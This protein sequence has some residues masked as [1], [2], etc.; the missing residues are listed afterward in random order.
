MISTALLREMR[1]KLRAFRSMATSTVGGRPMLGSRVHSC[2]PS[3]SELIS[4][5]CKG[6]SVGVGT[7]AIVRRKVRVAPRKGV[8]V[9]TFIIAPQI[10]ESYH[11]ITLRSSLYLYHKK[12]NHPETCQKSDVKIEGIEN[13][14]PC[15]DMVDKPQDRS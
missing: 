6:S 7:S 5:R 10:H 13:G 9:K 1:F 11:G 15:A 12:K 3:V 4:R 8:V 2:H 14:S